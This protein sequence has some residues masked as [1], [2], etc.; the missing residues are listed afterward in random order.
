M[1]GMF[2]L[3]GLPDLATARRPFEVRLKPDATGEVP[4]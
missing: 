4:Y 3:L 2:K 1:Y